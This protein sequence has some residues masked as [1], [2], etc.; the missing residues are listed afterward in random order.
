M[1]LENIIA[2]ALPEATASEIAA[3][4]SDGRNFRMIISPGGLR[5]DF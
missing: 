4:A 3:A 2:E 5:A 1:G